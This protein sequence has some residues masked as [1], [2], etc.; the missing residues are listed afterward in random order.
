M[1]Y[2]EYSKKMLRIAYVLKTVKRFRVLILC[3]L[4]AVL[5]ITATLIGT[6]GLVY[7]RGEFAAEITYGEDFS[8]S[9]G[10][11][12]KSVSYEYRALGSEQWT[13]E[14]PIRAGEYYVRAVSARTGGAPSYGK[15]HAFKILPRP[16]VVSVES[17]VTYGEL[18]AVNAPL[19]YGDTVSCTEFIYDDVSLQETRVRAVLSK[20]TVTDREGRDVTSSYAL[21][22]KTCDIAFTA[23]KIEVTV[24]DA[25]GIYDGT[26]FRSEVFEVSGGTLA[27]G[28]NV[29]AVFT[30]SQVECGSAVNAPSLRVVT[31]DG[32]DVS[33]NYDITEK[34]G[35]LI[36]DK[37]P[38]KITTEGAEKIYD[39]APL[40]ADG[41]TLDPTLTLVNGHTLELEI[42]TQRTLAGSTDNNK[43]KFKITDENG[44]DVT[45]NYSLEF[46][47]GS[48]KVNK[49]PITVG[50]ASGTFEYDATAHSLPEII[51]CSQLPENHSAN[52][53]FSS[54]TKITN[55]GETP[56]DT[57]VKIFS[58]ETDV[59]SSFDI[60][61]NAG[62]LCVT[63]RPILV[64]TA[65][66]HFEY[67]GTV[68]TES[69]FSVHYGGEGDKSALAGNQQA[70]VNTDTQSGI[71]FVSE[72]G[73]DNVFELAVRLGNF[74]AS[75]NYEIKYDYG[76]L[77]VS[78]RPIT[79][80]TYN[81]D[82]EYDGK[83][84][85]CDKFDDFYN[86][87]KGGIVGG[88]KAEA[89]EATLTYITNVS[90]SGEK[91]EFSV[92]IFAESD[93]ET[94]WC[95]RLCGNAHERR[96]LAASG[97]LGP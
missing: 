19:V 53:D 42:L 84:F 35:R 87:E 43:V 92:R 80:V 56:N 74:D 89:N 1:L 33:A 67:T 40:S 45:D 81:E 7:D 76:K 66:G 93:R 95:E 68:H 6:A 39:G 18:P 82:H 54:A 75:A 85:S 9:A 64:S 70:Y 32:T 71:T 36:V 58:G 2:S 30:A 94:E 15:E 47:Y 25:S 16:A 60:T 11:F 88:D 69:G 13:S 50:T 96:E 51:S 63:P 20:V 48:L 83:V 52:I 77:Y 73:K 91:N 72:S 8:Y 5:G 46:T 61:Y 34:S 59:S 38:L 28:D 86:G 57:K 14:K 3:C 90:E 79:V 26:P 44:K 4:L 55:A 12:L 31:S 78:P 62:T 65:N 22:A 17:V 97:A 29:I 10:A 27:N 37:R 21:T 49:C 41:Y 23:R 24:A